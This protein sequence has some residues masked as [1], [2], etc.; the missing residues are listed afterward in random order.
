MILTLLVFLFV[1][2]LSLSYGLQGIFFSQN[3]E[4][5]ICVYTA[6]RNLQ[7]KE[8]QYQAFSTLSVVPGFLGS[9][10]VA[11]RSVEKQTRPVYRYTWGTSYGSAFTDTL[12]HHHSE[13]ILQIDEYPDLLWQTSV[14]SSHEKNEYTRVRLTDSLR[15]HFHSTIYGDGVHVM[16]P[17][18]LYT[19]EALPF[20]AR[21][22]TPDS[23][24]AIQVNLLPTLSEGG[25]VKKIFAAE[26]E[27]LP[28]RQLVQDVETY[29]V[30]FTRDDNRTAEFWISRAGNRRVI[31]MKNFQGTWFHLTPPVR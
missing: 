13:A 18:R 27:V 19:E 4:S 15:I 30:R 10:L 26:G 22:M 1:G 23:K 3:Q 29:T 12:F 14:T 21:S 31:K 28:N 6:V 8:V 5:E 9:D 20:L 25:Y 17:K 16:D 2:N 24:D 7:G 11:D